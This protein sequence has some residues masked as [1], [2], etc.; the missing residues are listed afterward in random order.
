M[1]LSTMLASSSSSRISLYLS[2][3]DSFASLRQSRESTF[4]IRSRDGS[5]CEEPGSRNKIDVEKEK[6]RRVVNFLSSF[7]ARSFSSCLFLS[8]SV[9]SRHPLG[10][11]LQTD[12]TLEAR[13]VS[14]RSLLSFSSWKRH[15]T[16]DFKG[17]SYNDFRD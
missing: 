3:R 1:Q 6:R 12:C 8:L 14:H 17:P 16:L 2:L 10:C 7:F 13:T 5:A 9:S 4:A 11:I 15:Y